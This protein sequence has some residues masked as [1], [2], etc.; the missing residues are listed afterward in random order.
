MLK[1]TAIVLVVVSAVV[2]LVFVTFGRNKRVLTPSVV[3]TPSD[4][5]SKNPAIEDTTAADA[6]R[7][8]SSGK[9]LPAPAFSAGTWIN[10]EPLKIDA[11][12]GRVVLIEFWTFGCSNCRN[13]L[14]AVK[15]LNERYGEHGLTIIGVHSPEFDSERNEANVRREVSSLGVRYPVVTDNDYATWK[16][17]GIEAWPT[18]LVVDKQGRIRWRHVG[19]GMYDET[20][21]VVKKLLAE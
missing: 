1:R 17:Y 12:R 7:L 3:S 18:T 15:K 16:A 20:E 5:D 2:A 11:M 14:P 8:I 21:D 4:D 9:A 13:T 10:S 6:D 19:E